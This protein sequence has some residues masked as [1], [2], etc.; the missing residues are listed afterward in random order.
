[1]LLWTWQNP[2][3]LPTK[4]KYDSLKY[5]YYINN[6]T[7]PSSVKQRFINAYKKTWGCLGHDKDSVIK[8]LW[9]YTDEQEAKKKLSINKDKVL[10]KMD[11]PAACVQYVCNV[12]WHW[13]LYGKSGQPCTPPER[14]FQLTK[15]SIH[16]F[17]EDFNAKW[18]MMPEDALWDILFLDNLVED[19]S[20]AIVEHPIKKDWLIKKFNFSEVLRT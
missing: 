16:E 14:L 5:S 9:C 20:D 1:M 3:V 11:V 7:I 12:A 8:I 2:N 17:N 13:I 10:W 19:C 18:R 4:G 6:S 15:M